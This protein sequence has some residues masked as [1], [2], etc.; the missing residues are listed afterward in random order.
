MKHTG[1]K[2][3]RWLTLVSLIAMF[4]F[5]GIAEQMD[6]LSPGPVAGLFL[7]VLAFG[8]FA[9]LGGLTYKEDKL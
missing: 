6:K 4:G 1:Q 5:A 8:V 3:A 9:E 2:I 7:S